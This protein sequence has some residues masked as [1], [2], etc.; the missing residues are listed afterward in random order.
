MQYLCA[1]LLDLLFREKRKY[2]GEGD[3]KGHERNNNLV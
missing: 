2:E 3:G 1:K